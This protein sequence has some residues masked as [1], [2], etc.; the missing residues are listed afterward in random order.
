MLVGQVVLV[1]LVKLLFQQIALAAQK[2]YQ[3]AHLQSVNFLRNLLVLPLNA[4]KF[5]FAYV[6]VQGSR[7][8]F[9]ARLRLRLGDQ[10]AVNWLAVVGAAG[11]NRVPFAGA[12]LD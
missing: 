6:E 12:D 3:L 7:S 9:E 8:G 1:F 11:K 2:S 5:L 4:F 10:L